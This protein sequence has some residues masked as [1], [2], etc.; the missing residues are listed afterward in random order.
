MVGKRQLIQHIGNLFRAVTALA[1]G[2]PFR[3]FS[4]L[5]DTFHWCRAMSWPFSL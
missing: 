2:K 5:D 1:V 4:S 3:A